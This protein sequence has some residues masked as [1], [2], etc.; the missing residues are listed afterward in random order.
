MGGTRVEH[1]WTDMGTAWLALSIAFGL[2][3]ADEA[4]HQFLAWYN[5]IAKR[6]RSRL[7]GLPFPPVFTFWPWLLGLLAVTA[8]A[9]LLT[10]MAYRRASWLEPVA[11]A[12]ALINVGN[13]LLHLVASA[14]LGRRVPGV[15][16]APLLFASALWLL[17]ATLEAF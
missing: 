14:K 13:G 2:H 7:G 3:V 17:V 15:L 4:S 11:L 9:L 5:P 8:V 16:S 12:F 1:L 10:P 6:I